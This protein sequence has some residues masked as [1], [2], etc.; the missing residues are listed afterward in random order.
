MAV[1]VLGLVIDWIF[2]LFICSRYSVSEPSEFAQFQPK[3][4]PRV[5]Q[6]LK[7]DVPSGTV[8]RSRRVTRQ[9]PLIIGS[10]RKIAVRSAR[11]RKVTPTFGARSSARKPS[12]PLR[13]GGLLAKVPVMKPIRS[14]Q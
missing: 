1:L 9:K 14:E 6:R 10:N 12:V 5:N 11:P 2:L 8:T 13:Q 3:L 7:G 4:M